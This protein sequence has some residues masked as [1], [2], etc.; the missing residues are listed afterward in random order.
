MPSLQGCPIA[1]VSTPQIFNPDQGFNL[2]KAA[3]K[4]TDFDLHV[5][6]FVILRYIY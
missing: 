2:T 3:T 4:Q 6:R 5:R 1:I